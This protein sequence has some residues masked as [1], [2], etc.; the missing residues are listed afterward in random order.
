MSSRTACA[1]WTKKNP[2][3]HGFG[4]RQL[5]AHPG[6]SP[7]AGFGAAQKRGEVCI[8]FSCR[9][10]LA[11]SDKHGER[12][13]RKP[14]QFLVDSVV[15]LAGRQR[16][17][18]LADFPLGEAA[19]QPFIQISTPE[20]HAAVLQRVGFG[21]MERQHEQQQRLGSQFA[22]CKDRFGCQRMQALSGQSVTSQAPC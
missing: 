21:V 20:W 15:K 3:D 18:G 2:A 6:C 5:R 19:Q 16:G 10:P 13:D 8:E 1:S 17:A 14:K 7:P 22:V 9:H 4:G 11:A 12:D